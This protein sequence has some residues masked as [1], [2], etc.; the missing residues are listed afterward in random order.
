MNDR[1]KLTISPIFKK[2]LTLLAELKTHCVEWTTAK[3]NATD[4]MQPSSQL[5]QD[6]ARMFDELNA[7]LFE[8]FRRYEIERQLA[9]RD[10]IVFTSNMFMHLDAQMI[11][12]GND[13]LLAAAKAEPL[14]Q[15]QVR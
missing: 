2:P 3:K 8:K 4:N 6:T 13:V 12:K 5:H 7:R 11:T 1:L 14:P 9:M 15:I 10:Y